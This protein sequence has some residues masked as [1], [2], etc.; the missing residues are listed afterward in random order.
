MNHGKESNIEKRNPM[1]TIKIG[2]RKSQLACI[3]AEFVLK[4]IEE[5]CEGYKAELVKVTTTGDMILST[6][7]D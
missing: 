5:Y 1:R 6:R 7:L 4:Y 2:T 3:Q